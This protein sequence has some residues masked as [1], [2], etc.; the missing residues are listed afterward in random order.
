MTSSR[1]S[2]KFQ[3]ILELMELS[4]RAF[5][6]KLRKNNPNMDEAQV[7]LELTKWWQLRPGAEHG[8][9]EGIPGDPKRFD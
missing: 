9:G 7:K 4:E 5:L 8:D 6:Y 2:G 3:M 1:F